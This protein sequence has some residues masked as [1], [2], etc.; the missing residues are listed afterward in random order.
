M[1]PV[2]VQLELRGATNPAIALVQIA[3]IV[4]LDDMARR[5]TRSQAQPGD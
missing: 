5:S 3:P 1:A 4:S 2:E